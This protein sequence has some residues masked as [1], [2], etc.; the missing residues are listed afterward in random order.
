VLAAEGFRAADAPQAAGPGVNLWF[1][2]H[3]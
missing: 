2:V 3:R 1:D